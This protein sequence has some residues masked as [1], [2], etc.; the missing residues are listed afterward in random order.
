MSQTI[1]PPRNGENLFNANAFRQ[2]EQAFGAID[3][4]A[5]NGLGFQDDLQFND[6]DL[7]LIWPDSEE[8]FNSILSADFTSS[9]L[10]AGTLPLPSTDAAVTPYGVAAIGSSAVDISSA[11]KAGETARAIGVAICTS[12]RIDCGVRTL[13]LVVPICISLNDIVP[14]MEYVS[15]RTNSER[16]K[17]ILKL[18]NL[19]QAI[20]S[21]QLVKFW[22]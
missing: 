13:D 7:N 21:G 5:T 2:S 1:S 12:R 14:D 9:W 17:A 18:A 16:K 11:T 8:L 15:V 10:P 19:E 22:W 4:A 20:F 3:D 6:A